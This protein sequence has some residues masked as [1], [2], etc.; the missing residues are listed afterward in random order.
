[1]LNH[2]GMKPVPVTGWLWLLPRLAFVLFVAAVGALLW[3]S[4]RTEREDQRAI[5]ISDVLWLEQNL[6]FQLTHNEERLGQISLPQLSNATTFEAHVRAL[7]AG[8]TGLRQ[9]IWLNPEGGVLHSFPG[10]V[11]AYLVGETYGAVPSSETARLAKSMGQAVYSPAYPIDEGDWQFEVHVPVFRDGHVAGI[12][13][14]AYSIRR[15]LDDS[16]PWW[17]AERYR[18]GIM[19]NVGSFLG[20]RSKVEAAIDADGYQIPLDPPGHDLT[21]STTPYRVQT[22]L[23]GRLLSIALVFLAIV[24]LWSLWALRR[25]VQQRL[26]AEVALHN[27]YAFRKAMEDSLQTGMRARDLEGRITY[28]NPAF[29]RMVGWT[30]A[31][32]VGRAP[33]MPYW[34]D[35]YFDETRDIH[36]RIL[37]GHGPEDVFEL[38]FKRRDGELFDV[39]IHEAPLIDAHGKQTGWMGSLI[40]VTERKRTEELAQQQQERLQAT[41]RLVTMGEMASSLAHELNQPL[42]A[43][44]GYNTGCLNLLESGT[45]DIAELKIALAKSA[46]QA[47]RAGRIIR[48]IY[49]FVRRAEPKSEP[50][51]LVAIIDEVLD[52]VEADARRQEVRI[53]T[54]IQDALPGIQGDRVL[55]AQALLNLVRNAIDAMRSQPAERR[56]LTVTAGTGHGNITVAV[57]DRGSG[58][59]EDSANRLFEPFYT[60]KAEGMGMGL[61]ICRSVIEAH[62]GRLWYEP[63]LEGGS[64]FAIQF[65]LPAP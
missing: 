39:L 53:L 51:D 20:V 44:S 42:A 35:Q 25:H 54:N 14:G 56:Q 48:R 32:L 47:Q 63:N 58:I 65:P 29:C 64:I 57:A 46:E 22:P 11:D 45:A 4:E 49:E 8:K 9:V 43:I 17:L 21:L 7:L 1:M 12:A 3:L 50:C 52:L 36:D 28:V 6:R 59:P 10:T 34:P 27:E 55:I 13:V 2:S 23:V 19:D 30:E 31:E 61:N 5:L 62:H 24:V 37:A 26:A 60:T 15:L 33:P 41:A 40:D 38:K 18:I 16:I